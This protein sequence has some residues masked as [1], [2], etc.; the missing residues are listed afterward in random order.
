MR[1][2]CMV[3][4][5]SFFFCIGIFAQASAQK[6]WNIIPNGICDQ[7]EDINGDGKCNGRDCQGEPQ[8]VCISCWDL[9]GNEECDLNED[10]NGDTTCDAKDSVIC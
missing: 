7:E 6:C 2:L 5:L 8:P 1:K 10:K 4:G 9:N 3:I